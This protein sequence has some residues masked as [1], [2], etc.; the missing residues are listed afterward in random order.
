LPIAFAFL[1]FRFLRRQLPEVV[2]FTV[3]LATAIVLALGQLTPLNALLFHIPIYNLFR[4]PAR[5]LFE[6]HFA[7]AILAAFGLDFV[8]RPENSGT[9]RAVRSLRGA[10]VALALVFGLV[11]AII[12]GVRA[13]IAVLELPAVR[14]ADDLQLNPFM[15][16]G[17]AKALIDR[18]LAPSFPTVLYPCIFLFFSLGCM[19]LLRRP[20]TWVLAIVPVIIA[21]DMYA[22]YSTLYDK[23]ST[24]ALG[25]PKAR[26]E[27][28]FLESQRFDSTTYR[29]FPVDQELT[30]AYPLL[31]MT[32]GW[33]VV[34]DYTPM[35]LKR[36]VALTDFGLNG[37]MPPQ[38]LKQ[39]N[40]LAAAGAQFLVTKSDASAEVLRVAETAHAFS[41]TP[42]PGLAPVSDHA[43][44]LGPNHY[45]LQSPD[46]STVS[47]LMAEVS[48]HKSSLYRIAFDAAA[49]SGVSKPLLVNLYAP[50][51]DSAAQYA[52][53]P[54]L[55]PQKIHEVALI[56]SG[57]KAPDRAVVRIYTQSTTPVEIDHLEVAIQTPV[58]TAPVRKPY[59][60]V[61]LGAEGIRIFRSSLAQPRFRFVSLLRP[62]SDV[63]DARSVLESDPSFD[64]AT[65]ALVEGIPE[66][67]SVDGGEIV[68]RDIRNNS[69]EFTLK[70]GVRSFFVVG[71]SW[72][73]GWRA[74]I[75]GQETP[76]YVVDGFLRGIMLRGAG[77]HKVVMSYHPWSVPAGLATT[78]FGLIVIFILYRFDTHV[79]SPHRG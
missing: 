61:F 43:T 18:N 49:P 12:E 79:A 21:A 52:V 6:A 57:L 72:F 39:P 76:I 5:H 1:A 32:Y 14:A 73:P 42:L 41:A 53:Y 22:P 28:A 51:Y 34:N 24:S 48:L 9:R 23:P 50:G 47:M 29:M 56:D 54:Q 59:E 30:Y 16:L 44:V 70:T 7:I 4:A 38:T 25:H 78:V 75:D 67:V 33:S 20:R 66:R 15:T 13:A 65:Q 64:V 58:Q 19:R 17:T 74:T 3:V 71:D 2:F 27:T 69:M 31:N 26:P 62:S 11:Y 63:Y 45:R 77:A 60:Q 36:Y 55:P 35:W 68:T 46:G 40:V 10:A 8:T 37:A